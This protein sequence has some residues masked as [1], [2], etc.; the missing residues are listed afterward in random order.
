MLKMFKNR[1]AKEVIGSWRN[2]HNEELHNLYSSPDVI[3]MIKLNRMRWV[4]H[5]ACMGEKRTIHM[6]LVG[7]PD[8]KRPLARSGHRWED[9]I[10]MYLREIEW[11][12]TDYISVAQVRD[13]WWWAGLN[14][15]MNL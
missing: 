5:V 10:Q 7:K 6:V 11:E 2:L 1:S 3:R 12:G 15:F 13:R 4:G 9:N 8:G 14:M